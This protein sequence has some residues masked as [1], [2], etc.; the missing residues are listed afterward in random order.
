MNTKNSLVAIS[1]LAVALASL[2]C[3]AQMNAAP[4][5][6]PP[7][8]EIAT[9]KPKAASAQTRPK[10]K[11]GKRYSKTTL[12]AFKP[13]NAKQTQ[14][15][16]AAT[17]NSAAQSPVLLNAQPVQD[18]LRQPLPQADPSARAAPFALT[19]KDQGLLAADAE[20]AVEPAPTASLVTEDGA[21]TDPDGL[22]QQPSSATDRLNNKPKTG[23][24][25]QGP[26][27]L[28]VKDKA[29]RATVQIPLES[30]KP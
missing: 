21:A 25:A 14:A 24:I 3:I 4:V 16:A 11:S 26:F 12:S 29:V 30:P 1:L 6:T 5:V 10:K 18:P 19:T 27:R 20:S 13:L 8:S 7:Q 17:E 2:P 15:P 23:S 28:R 22:G 9:A